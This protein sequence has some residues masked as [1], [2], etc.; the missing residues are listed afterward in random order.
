VAS[1][2]PGSIV[3]DIRGKVGP[4]HYSRG[5]AGPIVCETGNFT[6]GWDQTIPQLQC[7]AALRLLSRAWSTL[8]SQVERDAWTEYDRLH[9][10]QNKF[11]RP[12]QPRGYWCWLKHNLYFARLYE[13]PLTP[14][15]PTADPLAM[16]LLHGILNIPANIMTFRYLNMYP[17]TPPATLHAYVRRGRETSQG[18][19]YQ[20]NRFTHAGDVTFTWNDPYW[21]A[22]VPWPGTLTAGRRYW[23]RVTFQDWQTY[24]I[25]R[26]IIQF[27]DT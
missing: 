27:A 17:E 7:V 11:G 2:I 3:I 24:A 4:L 10:R 9:P 14:T 6:A 16:P 26:P 20:T 13:A 12:L 8:L 18:C 23:Y 15:P 25:S 1:I 19:M 22:D 5:P 21:T